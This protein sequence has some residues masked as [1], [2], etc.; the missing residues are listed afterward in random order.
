[1]GIL[2]SIE[3]QL[4]YDFPVYSSIVNDHNASHG[5]VLPAPFTDLHRTTEARNMNIQTPISRLRRTRV[6][7]VDASGRT[8]GS[9]TRSLTDRVIDAL[10]SDH[11]AISVSTRDVA[12]G[13][14]FVDEAWIGATFTAVESRSDFQHAA[15][16]LSDALVREVQAA[17]V[18][19]IGVPVYNFGVPASL[20]A[21]ID[22]IARAGVT[23]RYTEN[24]PEGLLS[25][26][27]VY[28]VVASGGVAVDSEADFATPYMRHALAFLGITD[29]EVVVAERQNV[30]GEAAVGDALKHIDRIDFG[31]AAA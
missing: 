21:W 6:L 30:V 12:R 18:L 11:G 15:L 22:M 27:K 2:F 7:R 13:I 16:S 4:V 28:L 1:M 8:A 19:V 31:R 17:D 10:R 5:A 29:V 26:K 24:G 3:E 14:P 25:G 23:F 9:T 20:K